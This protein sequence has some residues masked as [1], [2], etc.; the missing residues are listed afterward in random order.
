MAT[1]FK[2]AGGLSVFA[3][4]HWTA[5]SPVNLRCAWRPISQV[6]LTGLVELFQKQPQ[7]ILDLGQTP[8][9]VFALGNKP[10]VFFGEP[11]I[12]PNTESNVRHIRVRDP[13]TPEFFGQIVM[14]FRVS[15]QQRQL[16]YPARYVLL[17]FF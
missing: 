12:I 17:S 8:I 4:R 3:V 5:L 1:V 13:E 10:P 7:A 11:G 6:S 9:L 14:D 15:N 16:A 2:F